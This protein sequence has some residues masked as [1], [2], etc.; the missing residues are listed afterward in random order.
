VCV[1]V[2]VC[3]ERRAGAM[4][5]ICRWGGKSCHVRH[6]RHGKDG[7]SRSQFTLL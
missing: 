3:D 5:K 4:C 1:C 7:E 2:C 6:L